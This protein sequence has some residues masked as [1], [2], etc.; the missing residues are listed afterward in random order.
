MHA[1]IQISSFRPLMTDLPGLER[2]LSFMRRIGCE[3]TQLQWIDRRIRPRDVA[4]AL[5]RYGIK[6]L[7]VQDKA[8]AVFDDPEY[9]LELCRVTKAGD[10]CV[11][12]AG[13][14]GTDTLLKGL[15]SIRAASGNTSLTFS[16]HPTGGDFEEAL[17]SVMRQSGALRLTLD[18]CQAHDAGRSVRDIIRRYAGRIEMVHFK[19]RAAD[20]ALCPVGNGVIDFEE[21]ALA[22]SEAGVGTLLAEQETWNDAFCDVG[23]GFEY[24]RKL[25]AKY[26]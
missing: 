23:L 26:I 19:D 9:Y 25:A 17:D 10:L 20:G 2:V 18:V 3:Y 12:G 15:D 22:C 6:A 1:G 14:T 16:F 11:S 13:E 5:D 24:T 21:A 7:G 4:C 8:R